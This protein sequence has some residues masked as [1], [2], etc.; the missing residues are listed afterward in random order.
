MPRISHFQ[1]GSVFST[2]FAFSRMLVFGK[3]WISFSVYFVC[4]A[5]R[6]L[7]QIAKYVKYGE[8]YIGGTLHSAAVTGSNT[9]EP[10]HTSR[11]AC[12]CTELSAV[13]AASSE[14]ICLIAE[15]LGNESTCSYCAG[16]SFAYGYDF[17]D[18]IWRNTCSYCAV[19][20]QCGRKKLPSG[21][22]P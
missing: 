3:S 2:G 14:L 22:I 7:I 5:D 15:D 12:G 1:P 6:N 17:L 10:S 19:A 16:V 11:A 18:F 8:R 9:V 4:C 13:S 21:K 20:G